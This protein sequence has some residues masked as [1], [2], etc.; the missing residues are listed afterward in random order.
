MNAEFGQSRTLR[1]S[2][3]AGCRDEFHGERVAQALARQTAKNNP[4]MLVSYKGGSQID[5]EEMR[6]KGGRAPTALDD[7]DPRVARSRQIEME[8]EVRRR[9]RHARDAAEKKEKEDEEM[10]KKR[11]EA[12]V[13][14][15]R[16]E[17]GLNER[18]K[19]DDQKALKRRERLNLPATASAEQCIKREK[20]LAKLER[21]AT[22]QGKTG[23]TAAQVFG[24]FAPV[25]SSEANDDTEGKAPKKESKALLDA[26][27][28]S[29]G[30]G[31]KRPREE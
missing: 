22:K 3:R 26:L 14:R 10:S 15:K 25:D 9:E 2:S 1:Q 16:Q 7:M 29:W 18:K 8:T 12:A 11:K 23:P 20:K 28:A 17:D 4:N 13:V 5:M 31:D 24:S 6:H 21:E 30:V 27:A 19:N